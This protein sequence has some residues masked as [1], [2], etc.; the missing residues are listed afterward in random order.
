MGRKKVYRVGYIIYRQA[1]SVTPTSIRN[2]PAQL[3]GVNPSPK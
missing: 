1:V 3:V 2:I